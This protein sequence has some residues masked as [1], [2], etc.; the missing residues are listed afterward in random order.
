MFMQVNSAEHQPIKTS[1]SRLG[2]TSGFDGKN[3]YA[4]ETVT[5]HEEPTYFH[6]YYTSHMEM[7]ADAQTVAHYMDNHREWFYC[8]AHPMKAEPLNENG[9]TLTIGK[10]GAF[11][12][13]VEPKIG[14]DL[15]PQDHGV[16][17]IETIPIANDETP[18]YEVDFQAAMLLIEAENSTA[19]PSVK[20]TQVQWELNLD[21]A[22]YF[23]RFIQALPKSLV[24]STGDRLLN[25]IIRQVSRR[26]TQ[27]VQENFYQ[28]LG[29]SVPAKTRKKQH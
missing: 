6:G 23:P 7:Y 2:V 16:Y 10:F 1:S 20:M 28:S 11:G 8:C 26:L 14:L 5:C 4:V 3:L 18:G 27:K 29:I 15:L 22:I 25:Q 17:R 19:Q 24:Q 21:V 12:Y 13:E 9:Y